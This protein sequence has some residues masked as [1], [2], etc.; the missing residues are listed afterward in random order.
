MS[1]CPTNALGKITQTELEIIKIL[2]Q[3]PMQHRGLL[4]ERVVKTFHAQATT[5]MLEL[6]FALEWAEMNRDSRSNPILESLLLP[7]SGDPRKGDTPQ[8]E[9]EWKVANLTASTLVQWLPTS[10]GTAFLW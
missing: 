3:V 8:N 5:S 2:E 4:F 10:V 9:R 6:G 1:S 7:E